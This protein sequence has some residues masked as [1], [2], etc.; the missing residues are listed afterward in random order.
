MSNEK[1]TSYKNFLYLIIAVILVVGVY[2]IIGIFQKD[3]NKNNPEVSQN[4]YFS[5]PI[6]QKEESSFVGIIE[7]SLVP[8]NQKFEYML[9]DD[10]GNQ[11]GYISSSNIDFSFSVGIKVEVIGKSLGQSDDGYAIIKVESMKF[12]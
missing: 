12:K 8:T 2:F 9:T 11:I 3:V 7:K 6:N 5:P 10:G 1:F 4:A